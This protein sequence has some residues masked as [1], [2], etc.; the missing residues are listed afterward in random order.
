MKNALLRTLVSYLRPPS[1]P[2][3]PTRRILIVSTTGLGDTLWATPAIESLRASFPDAFIGCLTSPLGREILQSNPHINCLY[4]IK[5]PIWK[6]FFSLQKKLYQE[7]FDTI[8][9]FHAS[10]RLI[11][12]LCT[13]LGAKKIIGSKGINKDLDDLFTDLLP[14]QKEHEIERRL[15][16]IEYIGGKKTTTK[17]SFH[18]Q[19]QEILPPREGKWVAIHPGAKDFFKRWPLSHFI[20]VGKALM[21][22]AAVRI[23]ITGTES[24]LMN[25]MK[26]ALPGAEIQPNL[27]LRSFA[28]LLQQMD[29][30][31]CNDTGPFHLACALKKK[32]IALYS[33]TDPFLCGPY[34][35]P[36]ALAI[37]ANPS[38]T[39]CLKRKCPSPFC[40]RQ[41]GPPQVINQALNLLKEQ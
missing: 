24:S 32:A 6:M 37:Y 27:D 41:I 10:D 34:H 12:P 15:R 25:E 13:L 23:V 8:L 18:L 39:P 4:L 31:I 22:K 40:L 14:N 30:L 9:I 38:C 7:Q 5:R 36:E 35:A 29:L 17:L 26:Q 19:S 11:I 1:H 3:A 21:E 16:F 2:T 33:P 28:A 20:E